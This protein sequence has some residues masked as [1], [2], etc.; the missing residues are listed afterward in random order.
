V[1]DG[2]SSAE[3]E[4]G[5]LPTGHS[6]DAAAAAAAASEPV[7]LSQDVSDLLC[8]LRLMMMMIDLAVI[9]VSLSAAC[10]YKNIFV[11]VVVIYLCVPT[12]TTTSVLRPFVRDYPG[13]PVP[14][15]TFTHSS[16]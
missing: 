4:S 6:V 15:E 8:L 10:A 11:C 13:E 3:V 9:D 16:S 12:T 1:V 2:R 14:E 5:V 7:E